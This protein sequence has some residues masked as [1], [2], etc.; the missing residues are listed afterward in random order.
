MTDVNE[1]GLAGGEGIPAHVAGG[2]GEL[3]PRDA[4]RALTDW[5][6]KA[7]AAETPA[8]AEPAAEAEESAPMEVEA[9]AAPQ[10]IEAPGETQE[11]E[12]AELPLIDPPRSWTKAEQEEF[13]TYPREA[14]EK[15]ARREQER[16]SAVRRSQN[17]ASEL[18]K[19]L[20]AKEQAVDQ[21]RQ[22]YESALP[23]ILNELQGVMA[24][25]FADIKTMDDVQKMANE[26]WPRYVRWDAQQKRLAAVQQQVTT[27]QERQAHDRVTKFNELHQ[28]ETEKLL[29]KH[30]D[31]RDDTKRK[32]VYENVVVALKEVG[33]TDK[34]LGELSNKEWVLDHRVRELF[35]D[36]AN[37]RDAQKQKAKV[38]AKPLPPAQKP[39]VAKGKGAV[40][41]AEIQNLTRQLSTASGP[42]AARIAAKLQGAKRRAAG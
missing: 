40:A 42:N 6:R 30:P 41:D 38:V 20:S 17:E 27:A 14:Q 15:I 32:K 1:A 13:A 39:G 28:S 36:A 11:A 19:G 10:E 23:I 16:E 22:Q 12:P 31:L 24:G 33:F 21:A 35:M 8:R 25:E 18:K 5:R 37:Y 3:S 9:G 7:A 29:E 2:D 4:Q 34:E 26:D